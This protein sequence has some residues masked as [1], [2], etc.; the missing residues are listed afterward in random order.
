MRIL[1]NFIIG[2]IL[3]VA[4]IAAMMLIPSPQP[5]AAK[6]WEVTIM[7]DG[8]PQVLGIHLGTTTYKQAQQQFG[9]YGETAI[10]TNDEKAASIEAYFNSVNLGGLSAKL[11]LN[12][13][14]SPEQI[15]AMLSRAKAGKLQPSGAHQHELSE[16]DR[17]TLLDIP[18]QAITYIPSVRL[19][20]EMVK[21][22][23][24]EADTQTEA[25][26]AEGKTTEIWQ[27]KDLGL[28]VQFIEQQKT[29]LIYTAK[30]M[31]PYQ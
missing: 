18:V 12:L 28:I 25:T 22:R 5:P 29:L 26:D 6:P 20:Q 31:F 4:G 11:V 21:T 17:T 23:F 8:N 30:S 15:N 27:Y 9:I 7:A 16:T 24:G 10:F 14:V 1:R 2:L 19:N 13:A 3:V